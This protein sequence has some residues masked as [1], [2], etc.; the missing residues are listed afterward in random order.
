[1]GWDPAVVDIPFV[2]GFSTICWCPFSFGINAV[3][4]VS[5]VLWSYCC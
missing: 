4:G 5:A 1:V 3:D 2:P